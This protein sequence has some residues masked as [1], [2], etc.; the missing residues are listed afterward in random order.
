M[1]A[2]D[3]NLSEGSGSSSGS[4][5]GYQHENT[6]EW[7]CDEDGEIKRRLSQAQNEEKRRGGWPLVCSSLSCCALGALFVVFAFMHILRYHHSLHS[8]GAR[9]SF[10]CS[11]D[12]NGLRSEMVKRPLPSI[13]FKAM[14]ACAHGQERSAECSLAEVSFSQHVREHSA[15]SL[16]GERG[17][18]CLFELLTTDYSEE[19]VEQEGAMHNVVVW[20]SNTLSKI[21]A[22]SFE[23][24]VHGCG[25]K[26]PMSK[27]C[28]KRTSRAQN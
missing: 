27:R 24:N 18:P 1:A 15:G 7:S 17:Q 25:G 16:C 11:A 5:Y 8:G 4:N 22:R 21:A 13:A 28:G 2:E 26:R 9:S 10:W 19:E 3:T 12:F 23:Q 14:H 6:D 20:K